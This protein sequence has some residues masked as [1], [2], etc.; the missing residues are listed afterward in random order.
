MRPLLTIEEV[1]E[2]LSLSRDTVYRMSQGGKIPATKVGSQW[3][4]DAKEIELWV[5]LNKNTSTGSN[6]KKGTKAPR[7]KK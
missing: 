5:M 7:R 1:A 4:Y 2:Y 6:K 3:R